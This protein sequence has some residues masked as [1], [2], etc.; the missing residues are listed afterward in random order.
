[1]R[2]FN[3]PKE[4]P[5]RNRKRM[6]SIFNTDEPT[7]KLTIGVLVS[8]F[9][10]WN[11]FFSVIMII[12]FLS[13]ENNND[14]RLWVYHKYETKNVEGLLALER[15]KSNPMLTNPPWLYLASQYMYPMISR[16]NS[17]RDDIE[18]GCLFW[19]RTESRPLQRAVDSCVTY[20]KLRRRKRGCGMDWAY[21]LPI[22]TLC[23]IDHVLY[24]CMVLC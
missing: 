22:K 17:S 1:M 21:R 14:K 6:H 4:D 7:I 18:S 11:N 13:N 9:P 16:K 24:P 2:E 23:A 5:A 12:S 15:V 3:L 20:L 8:S 10:R 19:T